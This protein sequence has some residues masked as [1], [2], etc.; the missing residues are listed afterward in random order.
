MLFKA[1]LRLLEKLSRPSIPVKQNHRV[2]SE[3]FETGQF[4]AE[5]SNL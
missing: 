4:Q 3:I 2:G 1:V 5:K